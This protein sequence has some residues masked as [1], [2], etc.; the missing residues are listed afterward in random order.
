MYRRKLGDSVLIL[1]VLIGGIHVNCRR[2]RRS[3]HWTLAQHH[4]RHCGRL[5]RLVASFRYMRDTLYSWQH[6]FCHFCKRRQVVWQR[7]RQLAHVDSIRR[8]YKAFHTY[9]FAYTTTAAQHGNQRKVAIAR[10]HNCKPSQLSSF[11]TITL[12]L[13]IS[14]QSLLFSTSS[15]CHTLCG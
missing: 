7:N 9:M 13:C 10:R 8:I 14:V 3:C 5:K 6:Y 15:L 1:T 2:H 11:I 4:S 12:D